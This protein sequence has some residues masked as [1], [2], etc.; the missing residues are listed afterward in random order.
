MD[1]RKEF[2]EY[3]KSKGHDVVSS[4]PLIPDDPTLM[5]VNAGMVQFKDIFTGAIPTPANP[6][7]T[8]C[9]LC[10]RAGGKHN[11]L[12]NVG[13]T[14]RHHTLFEMLGNF[15]F[16]DY[17][18]QDAINHAWEFITK[19]L[20]LPVEK[21]WVTVHDSDDEAYDMWKEIVAED[22]I[23]R[24]GDADNF[25]S[26]GDTGAC[27]PC[28]EIFYDQ[29]AEHFDGPE[30]KMGGEGDRFLEIWNLVFMQ[31][32]RQK[33][34]TLVP[35][36][37]PS[38]DTGM[39]LERVIA[40]KEGVLNN[41]DSSQFKPMVEKIEAL[42]G[43]KAV[44]KNIGSY[45]VIA[46]HVRA[47]S[48]ML[49]DGILFDKEGRGYVLRRILRR[50]VRHGYLLGFRKPY[51]GQVVD[52]LVDT[53][54]GHYSFLKEKQEYIKEQITLEEER[55]F[56]TIEK[57]MNLF[58]EELPNTKDKFSGEVAFKLYDT[59]GFPLDL[60]E[61]MLREKGMEVDT[62]TFETCMGE[63]KKKAK[64][65]WKG[66]GDAAKDGDFKA[67][68]E[69]IGKNEFVGYDSTISNT[70]IL[71]LLDDDFKQVTT[72][73][74]SGWVMLDKTPFYATS[75]GQTGDIGA[76]EATDLIVSVEETSKFF[77][78]NLSKVTVD[79]GILNVGDEVEAIVIQRD[80]IEKHHSA[81]HLLQSALKIVLGDT[82]SQAGSL[83]ESNR[84]RFDFTYPKAMTSVQIAEVEDLVNSMISNNFEGDVEELPIEQA[85][86]K[87][88]IAMFGEKYGD[89]VRVVQFGDA[90]VEFC[91]GT[92]V[93]HTS[94]IGS[95]YITAE[96]GVSAGV[97][98]IEAVCGQA[99][100]EYSKSFMSTVSKIEA[101]VKNKDVVLG[102][103]KLKEQIKAL[104]KE[105]EDAHS[106]VSAPLGECE[107]NGVKVVVDIVE[108]GDLKKLVDDMKNGHEN[109][110]IF[111]LQAKGDKVMMV[112]GVKGASIKAGDWI[113]NIA[114][115]VQGGGGGRPDFAQAGGKDVSKINDAK[116]AALQYAQDNI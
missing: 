107:I 61:D 64:A 3:F 77:D 68:L 26:M 72:L 63:Q 81:T 48:F 24:F 53:M 38:I 99:A 39:G 6:K 29:G 58:N 73:E 46:D 100:L 75:G 36:P 79:N 62:N 42:C 54:S 110:A 74:T 102:V 83:N 25:W 13:Y 12:E 93:K 4:M 27:G 35:L 96:R 17:F 98:R 20:E 90:S 95:F 1:I 23:I 65:A 76:L 71:T 82:V 19:N 80:E 21:L 91:G 116:A 49:C 52:T 112:S 31:Y 87:G 109:V 111:L 92:H 37:K 22:R 56:K 78:I 51:M 8:S 105:L 9:Q 59:F 104:K 106:N 86:K 28:S 101:E 50:A 30:D 69:T 60:T 47:V 115:I 2:L 108:N 7:A 97:R 103:A 10:L 41:F 44:E 89:T 11:D 113:K 45:R 55:F 33:D 70:K 66:S 18:K 85:K 67:I 40:I 94:Q 5:F 88:A 84:L 57:G 43:N 34:G 114:P 32:D 14:A 15:S 16:G